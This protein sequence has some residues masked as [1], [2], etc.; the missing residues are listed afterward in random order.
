MTEKTEKRL[1]A[2]LLR[3]IAEASKVSK[4][5]Q[6]GDRDRTEMHAASAAG[7]VAEHVLKL[8]GKEKR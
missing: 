7:D 6:R 1:R 3:T 4:L 2:Y 8:L 5:W